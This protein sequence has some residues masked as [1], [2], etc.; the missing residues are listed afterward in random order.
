M[1]PFIWGIQKTVDKELQLYKNNDN[2][3]DD[4]THG[5]YYGRSNEDSDFRPR[6]LSSYFSTKYLG[7]VWSELLQVV[8]DRYNFL[9][10]GDNCEKKFPACKLL[11]FKKTD[12]KNSS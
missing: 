11:K 2:G 9:T 4:P 3:T 7:S 1:S 5:D 6:S 10:F 8:P 12:K